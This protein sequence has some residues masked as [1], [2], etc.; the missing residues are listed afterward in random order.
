[1]LEKLRSQTGLIK[2]VFDY[3]HRLKGTIEQFKAV[4]QLA[5]GSRLHINEVWIEDELEKYAYYWLTPAG[6][7]LQGW[8]NA[9]HH[10]EIDSHPHHTHYA[11]SVRPSQI[12]CLDDV[13]AMLLKKILLDTNDT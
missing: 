9:P 4:V 10:P 2:A 5:D 12:R 1:M 6:E 3:E 8:D 7:I 13:L 11:D